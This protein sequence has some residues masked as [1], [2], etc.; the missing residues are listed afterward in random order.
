MASAWLVVLLWLTASI[1]GLEASTCYLPRTCWSTAVVWD[2]PYT[3]QCPENDLCLCSKTT[4]NCSSNH[5]K[6]DY[7]PRV[8]GHFKMLNFSN[9]DLGHI[10]NMHFFTNVSRSVIAVDLYQNNLSYIVEGVFDDLPNLSWLSLGG[11]PLLVKD[12]F[13]MSI[14]STL[15][16]LDV[17]CMGFQSIPGEAVKHL[18]NSTVAYLNLEWNCIES[19]DMSVLSPMRQ[20]E[21]LSLWKN[22]LYSLTAASLPQLRVLNMVG[23]RLFDFPDT[24]NSTGGS[25]FPKLVNATLAFNSISRI[26][27]TICLP[28]LQHLELSYNPF[29]YISRNS[30]SVHKFPSLQTVLLGQ[31][32]IKVKK[33][34]RF[35]FNNSRLRNIDLALNQINFSSSVVDG[36]A[37]NGCTG[38]TS[39]LLRGNDFS[40]VAENRF[41]VLFRSL[42]NLEHLNIGSSK[43]AVIYPRAFGRF[44]HLKWL[45]LFENDFTYIPDGAFDSLRNLMFL[46]L[47]S[48][49]ISRITK[50]TF[51]VE[52]LKRLKTLDLSSSPFQCNCDILWFQQCVRSNPHIFSSKWR[53]YVCVN[54]PGVALLDFELNEQVRGFGYIHDTCTKNS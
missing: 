43:M 23:N 48:S 1:V 40:S 50:S 29:K 13:N 30:F 5:G 38:L 10:S 45:H 24:C 16:T 4:L 12:V 54:V 8:P 11:N 22:D 25:F 32:N 3:H 19:F 51:S 36:Q 41:A 31:L 33:I 52:T 46:H 20:L 28:K 39:L 53:P 47:D 15:S 17:G 7:V 9:N 42:T 37:F 49:R 21:Y 27:D 34:E 14:I 35:A 2:S 26:G 44:R 6:L 18:K